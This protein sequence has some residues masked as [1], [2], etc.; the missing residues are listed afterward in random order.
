MFHW[1]PRKDEAEIDS[2]IFIFISHL[3]SNHITKVFQVEVHIFF[4]LF[5]KNLAYW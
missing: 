2:G 5:S 4:H 1:N 3:V